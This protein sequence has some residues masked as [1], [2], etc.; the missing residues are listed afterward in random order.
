[1]CIHPYLPPIT[2]T[3][4]HTHPPTYTYHSHS[5]RRDRRDGLEVRRSF[6]SPKYPAYYLQNFHYQTDGW[7]SAKSAQLYDYQ[8]Q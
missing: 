5:C 4:T 8:V 7:M 3:P 2:P 1:M 6:S